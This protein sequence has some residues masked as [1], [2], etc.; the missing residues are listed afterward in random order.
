[1]MQTE[2]TSVQLARVKRQ[3]KGQMG[4]AA[5]N[6]ENCVLGMGKSLLHYGSYMPLSELYMIIDR[7]TPQEIIEVANEIFSIPPFELTYL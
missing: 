2:L 5:E 3:W 7:I 4:I 1:M 6:H